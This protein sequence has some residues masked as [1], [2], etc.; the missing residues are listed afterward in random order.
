M[1]PPTPVYAFHYPRV[2]G[3]YTYVHS[4]G[5]SG[6]E[7]YFAVALFTLLLLFSCTDQFAMGQT[8]PSALREMVVEIP[9]V[10][11]EDIGGLDEVKKELQ[12]LV[13]V[14]CFVG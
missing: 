10:T 8:N 7:T 12:E 1:F 5:M 13:Q 14:G 6:F 11:W 4:G 2:H 3:M 9:N